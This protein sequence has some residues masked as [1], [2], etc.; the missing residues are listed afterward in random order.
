MM[1]GQVAMHGAKVDG[2]EQVIMLNAGDIFYAEVDAACR[3]SPGAA[4]I[5]VIEKEGSV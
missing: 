3:P 1:D 5:L 4:R 2:E